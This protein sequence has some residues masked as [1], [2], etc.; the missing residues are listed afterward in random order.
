MS[1]LAMLNLAIRQAV[2][3]QKPTSKA[4][5]CWVRKFDSMRRNIADVHV[6]SSFC[7]L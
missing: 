2:T 4:R 7:D 5:R 6:D 3:G 1:T